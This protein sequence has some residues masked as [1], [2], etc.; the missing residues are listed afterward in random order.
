MF[1][2]CVKVRWMT[3]RGSLAGT[4]LAVATMLG[5]AQAQPRTDLPPY[6]AGPSWTGFYVGAGFGAGG[7]LRRA[8]AAPGGATINVDGLGGGGILASIHGGA[9]YQVI[10]RAVLGLMAEG[11]WSNMSGGVSAQVPGANANVSSQANLGLAL[12]AR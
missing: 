3:I 10:P 12:L 2:H 8:T 4:A 1:A 7:S 11:T 9:D 5:A 6:T